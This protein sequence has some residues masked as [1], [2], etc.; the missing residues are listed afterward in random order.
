MSRVDTAWLR[1]DNDVNLMMIVGVWL[2]QPAVTLAAVRER[3]GDKLLKYDRFRQ[4]AVVDAMGASWV[5]D[6]AFDLARHVVPATLKRRRGEDARQALQRLCGELATTPLDPAHPLWQFQLVEHY[7]GGSALIARIHHCIGDGIALISVM[8]SITD[9][10][11]DPPR[12]PP[13]SEDGTHEGEHDWLADAVIKP[14]TELTVKAIGMYGGGVAK[15][16]DMLANPY[17]PLLG[18]MDM[19][20]TGVQVLSDVAALAL[21]E[22]DSPT[23]LKGRP[24]GRKVVAWSEPLPL[25]AVKVVGKGLGCTVNDVLLACAAGAI[26]EYLAGRGDDPAG[27]QIRVMVPVNLRP[28]DKAWQLGNRF[29]LAPL[30]LPIG[31]ANPVERVFAVRA[32]MAELKGSYQPLLAF[33]VLAVSGLFIKPVQDAVTG[34][35]AKKTTAVMTNVPGPGTPLKFCGSTL[36]QTMFWVPASGEIG[37]G[38]SILSYGGGV[39]FAL[40]TDQA[41][42]PDPQQVIDRFAPEFEK[43]EWLTLMLPWHGQHDD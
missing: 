35:F 37:V 39:Q 3:I 20:R 28:L 9:G 13:A 43:L 2:L 16:I 34:M 38:V 30:V 15:S 32:R 26:G 12:R 14:L 8:L 42:C 5:E 19:A 29:G 36:R 33:G 25:D 7:D 41:L 11:S 17:Q 27:K 40:I 10:G 1:M 24:L 31:I 4:K 18:S 22:N 23:L 6:E 21:M